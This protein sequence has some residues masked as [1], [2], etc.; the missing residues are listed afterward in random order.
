MAQNFSVRYL[1][2][3]QVVDDEQQLFFKI[4]SNFCHIQLF[5]KGESGEWCCLRL[6]HILKMGFLKNLKSEFRVL[7][8]SFNAVCTT[9]IITIYQQNHKCFAH[10]FFEELCPD[11][12]FHVP[13][14]IHYTLYSNRYYL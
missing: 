2:W 8:K 5:F 4:C 6:T 12:V 14:W 10:H 7:P 13:N 11:F 1:D 9:R 3:R